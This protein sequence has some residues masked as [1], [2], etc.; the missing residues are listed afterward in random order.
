MNP[1]DFVFEAVYKGAIQKGVPEPIAKTQAVYALDRYKKSA[2]NGAK[3][4]KFIE[5][6]IMQAKKKAKG[7]K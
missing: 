7:V 6:M 2:F 4:G 3:V 1:Y 5:E